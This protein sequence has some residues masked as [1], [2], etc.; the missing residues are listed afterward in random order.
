MPSMT[1]TGGC[2]CGSVQYKL[3]GNVLQFYHC[4]CSRCR[5]MTGTG[6]ATNLMVGADTVEW[7]KGESLLGHYKVPDAERFYSL[8]CKQCGSPLPRQVPERGMVVVPAGSLDNDPGIKPEARI[9]WDSRAEWS[10][11][12]GVLPTF[13]EYP[14]R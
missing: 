4:H 8:F 10:C 14:D 12:A 5:K 9:F 7:V 3:S 1:F 2:L 11:D 6:H 13:S